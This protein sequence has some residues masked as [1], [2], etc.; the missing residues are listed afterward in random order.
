LAC[1]STIGPIIAAGTGMRA[2][3]VGA[4][5]LSMHSVR[6]MCGADDVQ[7]AVRHFSAVYEKFSGTD[8]DADSLQTI[9]NKP[10]ALR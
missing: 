9:S 10:D 2:V 1:G 6:E 8:I 5:M 4:P 3:D 7:H